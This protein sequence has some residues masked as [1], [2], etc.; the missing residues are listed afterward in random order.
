MD[1]EYTLT[2]AV[3]SSSLLDGYAVMA[4]PDACEQGREERRAVAQAYL[5]RVAERLRTR[6]LRVQTQ[7]VVGESPAAG[8]LD[9]ARDRHINL[10]ALATHGRS[11]L[12]RL[13]L[14]SVADKIVRGTLI[15]VLVYRPTTNG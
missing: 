10:I 5:D 4:E 13:F 12:K 2:Q 3:E 14:G 11:G 7:V 1:A 15:P 6:G 9:V 8:V